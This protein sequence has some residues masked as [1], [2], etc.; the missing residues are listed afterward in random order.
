MKLEC[1]VVIDK[2]VLREAMMEAKYTCASIALELGV[3]RQRVYQIIYSGKISKKYADLFSKILKT[4][5]FI[6]GVVKPRKTFT[7]LRLEAQRR[8]ISKNTRP[9]ENE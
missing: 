1:L 9:W 8:T 2:S 7:Q 3:T 4:D 6:I 5:R